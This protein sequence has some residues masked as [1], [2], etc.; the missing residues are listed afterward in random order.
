MTGRLEP[1][2]T[3][4]LG[5]LDASAGEPDWSDVRL[6]ARRLVVR[7]LALRGGT[8]AL[9]AVTAVLAVTP[10][11]GL[12]GRVVQ[13]FSSGRPAPTRVVED[14]A[15]LDAI[16]PPGAAPGVIAGQAREVIEVPLST[17]ASAV[18]RVAPT[19]AGGFCLDLSTNGPAAEGGG[20]CDSDRSVPFSA[21]LSIP[22]PISSTGRILKAPVVLDGDTL[23]RAAAK[24]EIRFQDGD[25][26]TV[27]VQW[28]SAPISAAFFVYE[29]PER[30]WEAGHRPSALVVRDASGRKLAEVERFAWPI[31]VTD[32]TIGGGQRAGFSLFTTQAGL[33]QEQSVS[34]GTRIATVGAGR[35]RATAVWVLRPAPKR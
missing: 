7:R 10:A 12:R 21:G 25:V 18:L 29:V 11:L 17:G 22:G 20:G 31:L 24:I 16:A 19:R 6:K 23:A 27:P 30:H 8:T 14:V 1:M 13:L 26:A 5:A 32:P 33:R 34:G 9:I 4:Q 28:V 2:L 3:A 15:Q 35:S